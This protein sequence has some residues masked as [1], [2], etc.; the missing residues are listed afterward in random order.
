MAGGRRAGHAAL[1][2]SRLRLRRRVILRGDQHLLQGFDVLHVILRSRRVFFPE[3]RA[4]RGA[5]RP[6]LRC[7][8]LSTSSNT[9]NDPLLFLVLIL[10][11]VIIIILK[12]A[13]VLV[14]ELVLILV[15]TFPA[16]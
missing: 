13:L 6:C 12:I 11:L 1:G 2:T 5:S 7:R 8:H 15:L 9:N 10:D 3:R 16:P 4:R 14:L